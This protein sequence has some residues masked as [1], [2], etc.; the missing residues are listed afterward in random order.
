MD[1]AFYQRL[2]ETFRVEADEH[3]MNIT[4]GLLELEQLHGEEERA[5]LLETT[6]REAHSLKGAARAVGIS[7]IE[8]ICQTVESAFSALKQ[9]QLESA[10]E[11][12]DLLHE[13]V[14]L[15]SG[16]LRAKDDAGKMEVSLNIEDLTKDLSEYLVLNIDDSIDKLKK[17]LPA[18]ISHEQPPAEEIP[19][20]AVKERVLHDRQAPE[21]KKLQ[22][23]AEQSVSDTV[24]ISTAKI[25]ELFVKTQ[26]IIYTKL[27]MEQIQNELSWIEMMLTSLT[28]KYRITRFEFERTFPQHLDN[29]NRLLGPHQDMLND[30]SRKVKYLSKESRKGLRQSSNNIENLIDNIKEVLLLPFSHLTA[31]FPK[32]VRDLGR[33]LKKDV[34]I[35]INGADTQCDKRILEELKDPFIHLLR[36]SI[37]HG[38]EKPDLRVKHKKPVQGKITISIQSSEGGKVIITVEDDGDG[39]DIEKLKRSILAKQIMEPQ[40][41]SYL[42]E[43]ELLNM[44]FYSDVSTADTISDISGRGLGMAIVKEKIEKL[45]GSIRVESVRQKGVKFTISLPVY[46]A[47]LRGIV[48]RCNESYFAIPTVR[49]SRIIRI[50]RSNIKSVGNKETVN[51]EGY[52]VAL[53]GLADLLGI[54]GT[55]SSGNPKYLTC[56]YVKSGEKRVAFWV[57]EILDER[58]IIIKP[59]NPQLSR[60]KNFSG[61]TLLANGKIV[62]VLNVFDLIASVEKESRAVQQSSE[63]K[64]TTEKKIL[65]VDD[66]ITSRM[67]VKDILESF[68]Y[69]VKAAFD[70]LDA[71]TTL[72][73]EHF[74]LVVSDVEMPRMSGF[75]LAQ[76]IR[77]DAKLRNLPVIL[78]TSLAKPE[79]RERGI[80]AGANAYIVKSSFDQSALLDT[81]ERLI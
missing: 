75:E 48:L 80:Q 71:Y 64:S 31:G 70:G 33:D 52:P 68:G 45:D 25:D 65:V 66:S 37:D 79:D 81:I 38:I 19:P 11:L 73:L 44:I 76:S 61:A 54:R 27:S 34:D 47:S 72:Q 13:G 69:N 1:Q 32:L 26:E 10:K 6:Y 12:F 40:R 57:D 56:L 15:I 17:K 28:D 51:I 20:A 35:V 22:R 60:V 7:E 49:I 53:V 3:L 2:L 8:T 9:G 55:K 21:H 18:D 67:L 74:D 43:P 4:N 62:P 14:D 77:K 46:L 29:L 24:R 39:I 16:F 63:E 58:E 42:T 36:N 23:A 41:L 50:N 59:F 5:S 78:V 30:L